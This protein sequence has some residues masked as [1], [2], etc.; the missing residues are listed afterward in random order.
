MIQI[1]LLW[2]A[3]SPS[4]CVPMR[5][6]SP[7]P[8]SLD[9]LDQS[10]IN[11]LV[12]EPASVT[13]ELKKAAAARKLQL[14]AVNDSSRRAEAEKVGLTFIESAQRGKLDLQSNAPVLV[15]QQA[16]WPGINI[17][18]A[19][20]MPSG[21]PWI[22]T[23]AGFFRFARAVSKAAIWIS[24][25]PP[26]DK[27]IP[28]SRYLQAISDA[29]FVGGH[30]VIA[31]DQDF[32]RR[33][34]RREEKALEDWKQINS[35]L[36]FYQAHQN[37]NSYAPAGEM[38]V[39]QSV[40]GGGLLSGGVLDMISSKHTPIRTIP[41]HQLSSAA[42]DGMRMAVNVI[43]TL[44]PQQQKMLEEF[45]K[46]NHPV[47][48][49][50]SDWKMP[51]PRPDQLTLDKKDIEK[52]DQIWKNVNSMT[53]RQNLGARLFNVSSTLSNLVVSPDGRQLVLYIVNYSNYPIEDITVHLHGKVSSGRLL[54]PEQPP[55]R[56]ELF[57][58]DE[59]SGA[60]ISKIVT[61]GAIVFERQ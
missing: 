35:V 10:S 37:W 44:N 15:S 49:P 31:L 5:W 55:Q 27:A 23:N 43:G 18:D 17:E 20:A 50:P 19:E 52:L 54:T 47:F 40:Q 6:I 38:A 16:V 41:L 60:E 3:F 59:G 33:L 45:R 9:L 12:M 7:E 36:N 25:T 39:I 48:S 11:C 30:W 14:I 21:A 22:D 2:L 58:V 24:N 4:D 28:I 34:L 29:R 46:S 56:I 57:E 8:K 42:L 13:E 26:A 32:S 1:A 53:N 51:E 61:V